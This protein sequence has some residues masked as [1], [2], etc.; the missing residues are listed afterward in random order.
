MHGELAVREAGGR[1]TAAREKPLE[2]LLPQDAKLVVSATASAA[3]SLAMRLA[4]GCASVLQTAVCAQA[5]LPGE[6]IARR[7]WK[8]VMA[9]HILGKESVGQPLLRGIDAMRAA[10]LQERATSN[11]VAVAR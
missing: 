9:V 8:Q 2:K 10:P 1:G 6:H 11:A 7:A 5:C 4:M 3:F